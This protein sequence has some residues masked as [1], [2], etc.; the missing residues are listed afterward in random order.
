MKD[1]KDPDATDSLGLGVVYL[2]TTIFV[3]LLFILV[4]STVKFCH[5]EKQPEVI[6]S[7]I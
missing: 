4:S 5:K 1:H 3:V 2:F 7:V 6:V